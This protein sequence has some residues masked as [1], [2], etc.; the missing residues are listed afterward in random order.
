MKEACA[1]IFQTDA[2]LLRFF[3]TKKFWVVVSSLGERISLFIL[4]IHALISTS[5]TRESILN[6]TT[7]G[8]YSDYMN[9]I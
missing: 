5:S 2:L 4:L 7:C 3:K 8:R 6:L 1:Q 9:I